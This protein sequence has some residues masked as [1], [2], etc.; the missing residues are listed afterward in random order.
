MKNPALCIDYET[1]L[2]HASNFHETLPLNKVQE[3][4]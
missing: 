3:D 2:I 1:F 4:T